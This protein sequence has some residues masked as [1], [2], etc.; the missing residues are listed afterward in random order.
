MAG[1]R[2]RG[3]REKRIEYPSSQLPSSFRSAFTVKLSTTQ[4]ARLCSTQ[5]SSNIARENIWKSILAQK[6]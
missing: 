5:A 3:L 6:K 2:P 1:G 4:E